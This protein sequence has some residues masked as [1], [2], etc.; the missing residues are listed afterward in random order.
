MTPHVNRDTIMSSCYS[1]MTEDWRYSDERMDVR[2]KVYALLLK[3][4]GTQLK[5][6][7][8]PVYS[9]KSIV[10]CSHDWVSQG[11]VRT[12]GIV[13]YYKAYYAPRHIDVA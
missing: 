2:A 13:A 10:E 6:D 7:G 11:N 5:E 1:T 4:F 9:Q 12:D 3:R 8:S